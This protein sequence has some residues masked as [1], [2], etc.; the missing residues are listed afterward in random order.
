MRGIS[1]QV[2]HV[3]A[4]LWIA[5]GEHLADHAQLQRVLSAPQQFLFPAQQLEPKI[6]IPYDSYRIKYLAM[7]I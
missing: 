6:K 1:V 2:C 4:L 7:K 3:A 5:L